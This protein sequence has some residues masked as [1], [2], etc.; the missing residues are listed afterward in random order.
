MLKLQRDHREPSS[1]LLASLASCSQKRGDATVVSVYGALF[2]W[3]TRPTNKKTFTPTHKHSLTVQT[4]PHS[5]RWPPLTMEHLFTAKCAT[6]IGAGVHSAQRTAT[7]KLPNQLAQR[8]KRKGG[9]LKGSH[10]EKGEGAICQV[11]GRALVFRLA[12]GRSFFTV[13]PKN[14]RREKPKQT[15]TPQRAE[16]NKNDCATRGP[17]I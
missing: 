1:P 17:S 5:A 10:R 9:H 2:Y 3:P 4:R 7:T 8:C 14:G 12:S 15:N 16:S 13:G 11:V 6:E